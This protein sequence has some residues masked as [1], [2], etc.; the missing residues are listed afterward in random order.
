LK[1]FRKVDTSSDSAE[2]DARAVARRVLFWCRAVVREVEDA[3]KRASAE[4]KEV[5]VVVV[6]AAA[7]AEGGGGGGAEEDI[8]TVAEIE[9]DKLGFFRS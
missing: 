3:K 7:A 1:D 4:E 2:F 5:A 9:I 8:L 6:A